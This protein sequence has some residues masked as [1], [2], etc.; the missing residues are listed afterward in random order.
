MSH[1][2]VRMATCA[3]EGKGSLR[4]SGG[5]FLSGWSPVA[6]PGEEQG[7]AGEVG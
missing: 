3:F 6:L 4:L 5:V 2:K 1:V 7:S